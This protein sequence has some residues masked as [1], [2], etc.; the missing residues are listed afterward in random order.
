MK[1]WVGPLR[2]IHEIQGADTPG[3]QPYGGGGFPVLAVPPLAVGDTTT[4]GRF[5]PAPGLTADASV[6]VYQ[7]FTFTQKT[8]GVTVVPPNPTGGA[9]AAVGVYYFANSTKSTASLSL[10]GVTLTPGAAVAALWVGDAYA[11]LGGPSN[12]GTVSQFSRQKATADPVSTSA[13]VETQ[14]LVQ[15]YTTAFLLIDLVFKNDGLALVANDTNYASFIVTVYDS[16]HAVVATYALTTKTMASGG[17]GDVA[18]TGQVSWSVGGS[19]FPGLYGNL[20]VGG[21]PPPRGPSLRPAGSAAIHPLRHVAAP[22]PN[23]EVSGACL[24]GVPHAIRAAPRAVGAT[25]RRSARCAFG[26]LRV[27]VPVAPWKTESSGRWRSSFWPSRAGAS[28]PSRYTSSC[29]GGA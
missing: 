15:S 9:D 26:N 29:R 24:A 17:T 14:P 1:P 5:G 23:P 22:H 20:R 13:T 21:P 3:A 16:T 28:C 12:A 19:V 11:V 6:D 27:R 7:A 25:P 4:S 18:A 10:L 2:Q 8:A